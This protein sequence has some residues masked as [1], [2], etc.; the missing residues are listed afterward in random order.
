LCTDISQNIVFI[1]SRHFLEKGQAVSMKKRPMS[2]YQKEFEMFVEQE[3]HLAL[4][5]LARVEKWGN[6][7]TAVKHK[8]YGGMDLLFL[9]PIR[10]TD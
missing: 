6:S 10:R 3:K 5:I 7:K 8:P 9:G 4:M 1:T 2:E